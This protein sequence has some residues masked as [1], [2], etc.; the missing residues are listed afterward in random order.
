MK[1]DPKC[2]FR[3]ID[4]LLINVKAGYMMASAHLNVY[5]FFFVSTNASIQPWGVGEVWKHPFGLSHFM[6]P[7]WL[8]NFMDF[9][10]YIQSPIVAL[11]VCFHALQSN[12]PG[13]VLGFSSLLYSQDLSLMRLPHRNSCFPLT[14][15]VCEDTSCLYSVQLSPNISSVSVT[16][17]ID[18]FFTLSYVC[19]I[20]LVSWK[21]LYHISINTWSAW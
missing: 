3:S 12:M 15:G 10:I 5:F 16:E 8:P 13:G 17:W 20:V 21:W 14:W 11:G 6:L 2:E 19:Q 7:V 1:G 4:N 9:S 18:V